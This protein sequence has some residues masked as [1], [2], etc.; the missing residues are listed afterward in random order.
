MSKDKE[1]DQAPVPPPSTDRELNAAEQAE[2]DLHAAN[3]KA[4]N[5]VTDVPPEHAQS[6]RRVEQP[7]ET[8]A[9]REAGPHRPEPAIPRRNIVGTVP[10]LEPDETRA[11]RGP[12]IKVMATQTG[13]YDEMRRRTGDVFDIHNLKDFS[14]R[15]M[16]RVPADTPNRVTTGQ[17]AIRQQHDEQL[18]GQAPRARGG[19]PPSRAT[20]EKRVLGDED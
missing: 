20:G 7:V 16:V 12:G 5:T 3:R 14:D 9:Q 19:E 6:T 13:Y 18:A 4:A 11:V 1:K 8:V 17:Q 10:L 15:W 2:A